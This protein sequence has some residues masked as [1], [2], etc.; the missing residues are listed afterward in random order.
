MQ[1]PG[2]RAD[3]I[4]CQVCAETKEDTE[5]S[6]HLPGHDKCT[7][8]PGWRV[9]CSEDGNG[10]ALE[11]HAD[12]HEKTSDEELLPVL[13]QG[14]TD[15]SQKTEDSADEDS[16]WTSV[17]RSSRAKRVATHSAT[18]E[19]E[20]AGVGQ[21]ATEESTCSGQPCCLLGISR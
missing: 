21:P 11:T 14:T 9:L 18:T 19:V 4:D 3:L 1:P 15:R 17:H 13:S 5:S 7:T 2:D 8:D 20:V 6:P 10:G 12:T 16:L